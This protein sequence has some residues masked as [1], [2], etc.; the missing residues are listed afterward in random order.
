MRGIGAPRSTRGRTSN[1]EAARA[2]RNTPGPTP[3]PLLRL[4]GRA[5]GGASLGPLSAARRTKESVY[6]H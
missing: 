3:V 2:R 4:F 5:L 1:G 6:I